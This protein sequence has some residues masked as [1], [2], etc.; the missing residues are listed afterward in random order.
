MRRIP[1]FGLGRRSQGRRG[2]FRIWPLLLFGLFF[3][4]YITVHRD[5]VPVSGRSQ[6]V[7][8][9]VQQEVA[10]GLSSYRNILSQSEIVR[11]GGEVSRVREVG[12]RIAEVASRGESGENTS[13]F[14]WEFNVIRSDQANAFALPGGKVGVNTGILPIAANDDGLAAIIG[15]E[16]AHA[17]A[18]HGAERMTHQRLA[19]FGSMAMAMS[20]GEMDVQTQRAVMA[21]LGV[22]TQFGVLLPFS[23]KHESEADFIGL[24]YLAEACFDPQEAPKLWKRMQAAASSGQPLELLSTHP[25]PETRIRQF[26]EWMPEAMEIYR[27][28]CSEGQKEE[29]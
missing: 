9:S 15:H 11:A 10:L 8:L 1:T 5:T 26:E 27:R 20:V 22:G 29:R 13:S 19:Q 16:I 7:D 28:N 2:R 3:L 6:L 17:V 21:A 18:R 24:R 25:A 4:Y 12:R 23:R 14:K